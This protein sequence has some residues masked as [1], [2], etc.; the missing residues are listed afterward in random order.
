M[1][2][3]EGNKID[4]NVWL[5][6][7]EY[8]RRCESG[9]AGFEWYKAHFENGHPWKWV[10]VGISSDLYNEITEHYKLSDGE[11]CGKFK[12]CIEDNI[13]TK[14]HAEEIARLL[15][16]NVPIR[17]IQEDAERYLPTPPQ[18]ENS[19]WLIR[20]T[21]TIIEECI[22]EGI[23]ALRE[24]GLG[25]NE[26]VKEIVNAWICWIHQLRDTHGE[27]T[28]MGLAWYELDKEPAQR[29]RSYDQA[30]NIRDDKPWT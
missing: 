13:N 27:G 30:L 29:K 1:M 17:E 21:A 18:R 3:M 23:P 19:A 28:S 11:N 2:G 22:W 20:D 4:G 8:K 12:S 5:T 14:E 15:V 7:P 6:T 10:R 9:A 26:N 25:R 16:E 24:A